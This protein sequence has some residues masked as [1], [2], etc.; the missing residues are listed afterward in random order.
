LPSKRKVVDPDDESFSPEDD[1]DLGLTGL[2]DEDDDDSIAHDTAFGFEEAND[3][4]ELPEDGEGERWSTDS[5][6][7]IELPE[8]A[9]ADLFPGE[10][11]GWTGDDEPNDDDESF[12][13]EL[14]DEDLKVRD[15]GGEEGVEDDSDLDDL[16]LGDLP[17]LDTDVEE[18]SGAAGDLFDELGGMSL[19]E[20]PTLEVAEGLHWKVLASS[21][22][23][24]TTL[25][26]LPEPA[27]AL[28][29]HGS[30][31]F[32]CAGRLWVGELESATLQPLQLMAAGTTALA[33][34]EHDGALHVAAVVDGRVFSSVDAGRSFT[35]QSLPEPATYV[36]FTRAGQRP[37]LWWLSASGSLRSLSGAAELDGQV[38]AFHAD[39]ARRLVALVRKKDRLYVAL[40]NDAGKQFAF[41]EAPLG[42]G[43]PSTRLSVCRGAVLLYNAADVQC[44]LPPAAFEPVSALSRAP[45]VL[46][47]EDDEAFV[48]S[49][50]K[51]SAG[52]LIVRRA[53]RLA[54]APPTVVVTLSPELGEPQLLAA[55]YAEGGAV[56]LYLALQSALLR[57][58]ASLD[59]EELA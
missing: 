54:G 56:T 45:A 22:V 16:D 19:S 7:P 51:S 17:E 29:A 37:R 41:Y 12:D 14:A 42:A 13:A 21:S 59:G 32:V 35:M 27:T 48:Y 50:V 9:D 38:L 36:G 4:L 57:I 33:L 34:T 1:S 24:V 47:N 25:A 18:D 52:L 31:L 53:A 23:R 15:D 55:S 44:A 30:Q 28:L 8:E 49:C 2:D 46:A 6:E 26:T 5:D 58:D 20:E 3:D 43:D 11:Y 40:S 10:E 39:G